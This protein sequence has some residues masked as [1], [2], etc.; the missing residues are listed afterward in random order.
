MTDEQRMEFEQICEPLMA[1]LSANVH[2]HMTVIVTY[3]SAELVE[4][5]VCHR[6]NKFVRD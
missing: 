5:V 1:W 2:P 3:D 6:T 4:G